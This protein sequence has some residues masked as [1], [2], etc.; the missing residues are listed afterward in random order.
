VKSHLVVFARN[1]VPGT[2]KTRLQAR[3]TPQQAADI[4]RA[5]VL[6]TLEYAREASADRH[7]LAYTPRDAEEEFRRLAGPDWD[8]HPQVEADLG[9][10]MLEATRLGFGR[11]ADRLVIIGS[12]APSLPVD[13]IDRAFDL[14][15]ERDVVLG[16]TVDGGYGLIGLSRPLETVFHDIKWSSERVFPQTVERL[17]DAGLSLG[18]LPPWYDVDTPA[19]LD[20]LLAHAA[21]LERSGHPPTVRHTRRCVSAIAQVH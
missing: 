7:I 14:L 11:G 5:L 10:R 19:D 21:A 2:V 16:P 4:Y 3:Y 15:G 9:G 20:F 6:D 12:D 1:P 18:V 17:E 8:L 13:F